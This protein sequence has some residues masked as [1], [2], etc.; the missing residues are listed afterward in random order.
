MLAD[1]GQ[2]W[3]LHP[4]KPGFHAAAQPALCSWISI[5]TYEASGIALVAPGGGEGR[6]PAG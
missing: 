3:F 1:E 4:L 6:R 5:P 2:R